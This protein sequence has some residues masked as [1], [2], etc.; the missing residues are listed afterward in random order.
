M[1]IF[2]LIILSA[3][4]VSFLSGCA[5]YLKRKSC[6]STNWYDYGEKVALEGRRLSGDQFILECNKAEADVA[7]DQ[8]DRGFKEGM[9]KYCLPAT[10]FQTGRSGK[11]FTEE[12]CTGQGLTNLR[13]QHH[14][15]V[16]QYCDR[17]NG[18][19]AGAK[20]D[21]YNKICPADLEKA[22]MPEFNR[23][24]KRY[25]ATVITQNDKQIQDLENDIYKLQNQY[26]Y[27][28]SMLF[29]LEARSNL[30]KDNSELKMQISQVNSEVNS[31]DY[32]MRT[33]R[34]K[35]EKLKA[36]NRDIQIELVQLD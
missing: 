31:L 7:D 1:K 14:N 15:G 36:K 8:L 23:G 26:S 19:A 29:G 30:N 6:E 25:L 5:S 35:Q 2:S 28:K 13:V 24:R 4:S 18:Y 9:E 12:M 32:Q 27:K 16:L 17:A 33:D 20:G 34:D 11:F 21:P 3:V 10:V 22:F